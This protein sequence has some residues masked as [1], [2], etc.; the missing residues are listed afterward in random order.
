MKLLNLGCGSHYHRSWTNVDFT[1]IKNEVMAHNLLDGIPFSDHTYDVIYHSHV[2]EHFNKDDGETFLRECFRVLVKGGTIRIA[3]PDLERI[4]REYLANL[5]NALLGNESAK[6]NYEWIKLELYDQ[7]VRNQSGGFMRSYLMEELLPNEDY[8]FSRI[9]AEAKQLRQMMFT[10]KGTESGSMPIKQ[11][12]RLKKFLSLSNYKKMIKNL[13]LSDYDKKALA[14]GTFRLGGEIHQWMYDR[15]SLAEVLRSIGFE[16][17]RK[18][19]AHESRIPNWQ[20]YQLEVY[21]G[22]IRKPDSLFM[23]ATKS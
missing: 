5:K 10:P 12:R 21:D 4:A 1:G 8:V 16:D 3:V 14:I 6:H 2:L 23:E 22:Q 9:G 7:T 19:E 17:V 15:Y 18:C 13:L 20:I 11:I